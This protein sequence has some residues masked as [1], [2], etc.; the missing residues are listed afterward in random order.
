[1]KMEIINTQINCIES[2]LRDLME[3]FIGKST[4][5]KKI[6]YYLEEIFKIQNRL[7]YFPIVISEKDK[8]KKLIDNIMNEN[9]NILK[10]NNRDLYVLNHTMIINDCLNIISKEL[11]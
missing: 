6:F 10:K 11:K 2:S 7:R 1:M 3:Y 9:C 4:S 8:I 5:C